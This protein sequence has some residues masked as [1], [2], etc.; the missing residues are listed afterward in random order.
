MEGKHLVISCNIAF[1]DKTVASHALIDCGAT[2]V[3][4]V[5]EDF[6]RHHQ[7]PLT[8]LKHPRALEV[9]DGRPISSGDITHTVDVT[10]SIL[11]HHERIPMFVTKLGHYP[12][13]L[14]IPWMELHDVA[15]RFSS[16]TLTFGSQYCTANCNPVPTVAH[17]ITSEPPEPTLCSLA[18]K[19]APCEPVLNGAGLDKPN[20]AGLG[21]DELNGAGLGLDELNGAG[22]GLNELNGVGLGLD[23]LNGAEPDSRPLQVAALG[24][25]SFRRVANKERLAVFSLSLYEINRALQPEKKQ[26]NLA[27]YVPKEYHEFLPLFSEAVAKALP[28]HRPYDHKIPLR[29]GFTPPFGPLY[30]LSKTELQ[31]LKEWLEENLSKGFIRASSSPAASPILFVKKGDGSLRLCVDYRGLNEGTIKNRYPLPLLEETLMRLSKAQFFT[32]LDIRGAYNLVRMAEGEEWKTA[33]RTRYGLFESL[34]MPFGLTNAPAD[35][36]ALINDV[37]RQFLDDFCTAFLDDILIYSNTLEEHKKQVYKVLKALSDAGLHLKPEKCHFHKQEVKYL[38][39]IVGTKGVRM[40]PDKVSCVRD[41]QTPG[42]VTDVQCFLGFANFYRRF[43]RDYSKVVSPLTSL[44]KKEGGKYVPFVWGPAQQKAFEDLKKAFTTAPIL[45]HFD[46]DREIVV[47]TDA[48]DY[49]SAGVLSQYDDEG[50]LHPVAFYSKKHSPAECNYEIYDKELLAI[51]RAFEE[52][53]PHLEGSSHPIQVLSDHKNLEYFMST[54]LLNRR[55]ARWSEFL[56]RF[57]F[58]ITYRPGKAGGKP[59]ALTR[60]SGDL[61]KEGDERLLANQQAVL[62]PHNMTGLA[63]HSLE[64]GLGLEKRRRLDGLGLDGLGLEKQLGLENRLR[65]EKPLGLENGLENGLGLEK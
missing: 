50:I 17:A 56:S 27:D 35:F 53:R 61:P 9:I 29:E 21:L 1:G 42:N 39:F 18:S 4:F 45:R 12:I 28:P 23:K 57:D 54:K 19:A 10:L 65:L 44:T 60:R 51:V 5:D 38:G 32:T 22:P 52:W 30:S 64:N 14:G 40:D 48:S 58:R 6:A 20:G 16:R 55:Q 43:I 36:Q 62:K 26:L 8:P 49:V 33:F 37:L 31:A 47:E 11:D 13:V 63:L 34:V 41:W 25:R 15:I 59:D 24:G 3:A 2:G 46:Y 7:L